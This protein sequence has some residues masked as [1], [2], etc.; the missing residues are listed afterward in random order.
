MLMEG[1]KN[2]SNLDKVVDYLAFAHEM[3]LSQLKLMCMSIIVYQHYS[4][5]KREYNEQANYSN[6]I[7]GLPL[8]L[9]LVIDL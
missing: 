9:Y 3:N 5:F 6:F 7:S 8:L 2:F 4:R 1:F